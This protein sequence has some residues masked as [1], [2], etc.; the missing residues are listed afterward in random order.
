MA[1]GPKISRVN[2]GGVGDI[3]DR[4]RTEDTHFHYHHQVDVRGLTQI[5]EETNL[6][7]RHGDGK[8]GDQRRWHRDRPST[9]NDVSGCASMVEVET[10]KP[11]MA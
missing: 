5:N 3:P 2:T 9:C 8:I 1:E 4:Q 11:A 7:S 10:I 6:P